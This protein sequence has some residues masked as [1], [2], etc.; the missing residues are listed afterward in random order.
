MIRIS[1][2][3]LTCTIALLMLVPT[4]QS[5]LDSREKP[6][7]DVAREQREMRRHQKKDAAEKVYTEVGVV[8]DDRTR[9]GCQVVL[10][11]G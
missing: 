7:G 1:T 11:F 10:Q 5:Q 3:L 9:S 8:P 2:G 4:A 6:L